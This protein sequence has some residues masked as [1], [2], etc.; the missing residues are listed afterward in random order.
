MR[1]EAPP[2]RPEPQKHEAA[3]SPGQPRI[4]RSCGAIILGYIFV[5]QLIFC[6]NRAPGCCFRSPLALF[7]PLLGAARLALR[8]SGSRRR[9][10]MSFLKLAGMSVSKQSRAPVKGWIISSAFA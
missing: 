1:K 4:S 8:S 2:C 10:F 5:S 9:Y 3:G 6:K 7:L